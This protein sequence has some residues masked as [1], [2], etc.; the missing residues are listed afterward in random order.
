MPDQFAPT[1]TSDQ[2]RLRF[3]FWRNRTFRFE[4]SDEQ[5]RNLRGVR[6]TSDG[7]VHIPLWLRTARCRSENEVGLKAKD[8]SSKIA[9]FGP[10]HLTGSYTSSCKGFKAH[11]GFKYW[12]LALGCMAAV[13]RPAFQ[14]L[15]PRRRSSESFALGPNPRIEQTLPGP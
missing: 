14:T 8:L 1:S 9:L 6:K 5:G 13:S 2:V 7:A 15:T 12:V 4:Q 3:I 10:L 11:G